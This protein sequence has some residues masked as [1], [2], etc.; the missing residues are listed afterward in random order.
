MS[1][2]P[3]NENYKAPH[4]APECGN[5]G[6]TDFPMDE[7]CDRLDG[8]QKALNDLPDDVRQET[9]RAVKEFISVVLRGTADKYGH[10][11][12]VKVGRWFMAIGWLLDPA[13]FNGEAISLA[14]L[15]ETLGLAPN[16]LSPITAQLSRRFAIQNRFQAH[17]W[18]G[19]INVN[20]KSKPEPTVPVQ[21]DLKNGGEHEA[22]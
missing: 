14:R 16:S 13:I 19:R 1:S 12:P 15:S 9:A 18:R 2:C 3:F 10:F 6:A 22:G 17:N 7:I 20:H 5:D 4:V 8:T 11:A 21:D